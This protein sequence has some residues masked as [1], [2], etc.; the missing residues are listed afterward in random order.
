M[1][2]KTLRGEND[3]LRNVGELLEARANE[4]E[5]D[6][7]RY[8]DRVEELMAENERLNAG[9]FAAMVALDSQDNAIH[10]HY[11][12]QTVCGICETMHE[13]TLKYGRPTEPKG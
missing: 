3:W 5:A 12:V 1:P 2:R 8:R 11:P 13:I 7:D 4:S 10:K 6:R 9:F